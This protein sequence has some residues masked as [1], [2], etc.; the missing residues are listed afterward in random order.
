MSKTLRCLI[1]I[2]IAVIVIDVNGLLQL[3]QNC[4]DA[5]LLTKSTVTHLSGSVSGQYSRLAL[6]ILG[7]NEIESKG[8]IVGTVDC[9]ID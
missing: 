9:G 7:G 5:I 8:W 4:G 2:L 1:R 3:F 6:T